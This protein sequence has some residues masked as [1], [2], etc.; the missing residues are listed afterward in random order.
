LGVMLSSNA[1][2]WMK[3]N[4]KLAGVKLNPKIS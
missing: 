2:D 1:L 3:G 4:T